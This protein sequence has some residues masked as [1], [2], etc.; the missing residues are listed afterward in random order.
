M[1]SDKHAK[2]D[3]Y[4]V[5]KRLG[6]RLQAIRKENGLTQRE[7]YN[8]TRVHVAR[9]EKGRVNLSLATLLTLCQALGVKAWQVLKILDL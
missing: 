7:L 2:S 1:E 4:E 9:I 3:V 6:M 5:L 8:Q